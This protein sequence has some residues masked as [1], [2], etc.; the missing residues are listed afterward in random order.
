[1]VEIA[2]AALAAIIAFVAGV[3]FGVWICE[4]EIHAAPTETAKDKTHML[5][6]ENRR[7]AT[8]MKY[9]N[10]RGMRKSR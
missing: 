2:L 3:R 10:R 1:M 5:P 6:V 7:L 9:A 8:I 4:N